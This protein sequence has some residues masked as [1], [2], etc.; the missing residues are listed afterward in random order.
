MTPPPPTLRDRRLLAALQCDGRLPAEHVASVLGIPAATVRRRWSAMAQAGVLHVVAA[1]A[2]GWGPGAAVVR[3]RVARGDRRAAAGRFLARPD[4]QQVDVGDE[5]VTVV[6]GAAAPDEPPRTAGGMR[7]TVL[8][9]HV[10]PWQWRLGVLDA[11]ERAGLTPPPPAPG[12]PPDELDDRLLQLLRWDGRASAAALATRT[13]I[14]E[15]AARR[16]VRRLTSTGL[17]HT[18]AV[19]DPALVGLPLCAR[20]W[21][22]A[23]PG[24]LAETGRALAGHPWV[25]TAHVTTGTVNVQ[26]TVR[27]PDIRALYGFIADDLGALDVELVESAL[28]RSLEPRLVRAAS[29][30]PA[31]VP[32]PAA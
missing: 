13:G 12:P 5:D 8:H 28:V 18:Q 4:A 22:R 29:R 1:P 14:S 30:P 27:A 26:L 25:T 7:S 2:G 9:S 23:A 32:S 31:P 10:S 21:A 19:V 24:R 16:R 3:V 20:F 17:L 11:E 15:S 6:I